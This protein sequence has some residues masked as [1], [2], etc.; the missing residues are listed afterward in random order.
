MAKLHLWLN[1]VFDD[2]ANM[3]IRVMLKSFI[4]TQMY[5]ANNATSKTFHFLFNVD[6]PHR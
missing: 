2:D 4:D 6:N 5:S 3:A 1:C